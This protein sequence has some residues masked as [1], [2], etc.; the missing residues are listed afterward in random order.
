MGPSPLE[1]LQVGDKRGADSGL[2]E[3]RDRHLLGPCAGG[4]MHNLGVKQQSCY[5]P[6]D[7]LQ[8]LTSPAPRRSRL[9]L[10]TGG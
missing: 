5:Y 7:V 8:S 10:L 2:V 1:L 4:L 6:G 9:A 3:L